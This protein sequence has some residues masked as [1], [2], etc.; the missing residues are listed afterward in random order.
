MSQVLIILN[1]FVDLSLHN[2]KS[3]NTHNLRTCEYT[4]DRFFEK[5]TDGNIPSEYKGFRAPAIHHWLH[6]EKRKKTQKQISWTNLHMF[7]WKIITHTY[8]T[9]TPTN[10]FVSH[11][12]IPGGP[13]AETTGQVVGLLHCCLGGI[14]RQRSWDI[15]GPSGERVHAA[16]TIETICTPYNEAER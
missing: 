7:A 5:T 16:W 13:A 9:W 1:Q 10:W 6:G 12:Y 15:S 3:T 14:I 4:S 11:S 8:F 2:E